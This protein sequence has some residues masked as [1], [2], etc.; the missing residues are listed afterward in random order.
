MAVKMKT[1]TNHAHRKTDAATFD[2]RF[3]SSQQP[4]AVQ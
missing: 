1:A 4:R 3:S 2:H